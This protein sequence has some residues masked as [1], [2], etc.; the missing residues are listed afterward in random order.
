MTRYLFVFL[1]LLSGCMS[2]VSAASPEDV[3][4]DVYSGVVGLL[5]DNS[6][7]AYCA[8]AL[9]ER[10][11]FDYKLITAEHC[12]G[13]REFLNVGLYRDYSETRNWSRAYKFRVVFRSDTHDL[14]IAIP[15]DLIVSPPPPVALAPQ[16]PRRGS[17]AAA[18]GHPLGLPIHVQKRTTR[19]PS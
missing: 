7:Q 6:N 2:Q 13:D 18:I 17:F 3:S 1:M 14:A 9:V 12:V 11:E 8:G 16:P 10:K 5:Y 15:H 19:V 4:T